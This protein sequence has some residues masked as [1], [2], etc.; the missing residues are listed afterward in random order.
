[1]LPCCAQ[2]SG[3]GIIFKCG[4]VSRAFLATYM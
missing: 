3:R 2:A 1:M 4:E